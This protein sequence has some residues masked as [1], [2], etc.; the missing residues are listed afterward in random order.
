MILGTAAYMSPEQTKGN[1]VDRTADVWA[2]GCVLYE[3]LTGRA[4]F[5]GETVGEILAGV[6]KTEPDWRRLPAETSE[7]IRRLLRRSLHKEPNQRLRDIGDARI[8]IDESKSTPQVN[9]AVVPRASRTK[10]RIG[11]ISALIGLILVAGTLTWRHTPDVSVKAT[12]FVI[13]PP[14]RANFTPDNSQAISPDGRQLVFAAA[15]AD[16]APMLWVRPLDSLTAR[17]L[18]GTEEG[19]IPFWSPDSAS[20]G[21]FARGKLKRIDIAGGL[22]QTL[23]DASYALGGAWSRDGVILF[24]PTWPVLS[25]KFLREAGPRN[26]PP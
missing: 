11:W 20:V 6:L 1:D 4:V 26:Q 13:L 15:T 23:A 19:S 3:M 25:C 7:G 24:S 14:S 9:S 8:E 2:F 22:P 18:A 10:E 12:Q 5:Q 16:G 21:F 17:S